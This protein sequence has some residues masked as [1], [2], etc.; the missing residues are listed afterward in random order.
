[1]K[2]IKRVHGELKHF[3]SYT[4]IIIL[5]D[6]QD[7]DGFLEGQNDL[8]ND[9]VNQQ[10]RACTIS[11]LASCNQEFETGINKEFDTKLNLEKYRQCV[12]QKVNHCGTERASMLLRESLKIV[13]KKHI[14]VFYNDFTR[15]SVTKP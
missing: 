4:R 9:M 6:D 5:L 12:L 2:Y 15:D 8:V 3:K 10:D 7:E 1:M 13:A 11:N 14:T